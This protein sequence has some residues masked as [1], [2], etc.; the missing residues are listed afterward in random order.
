MKFLK[1]KTFWFWYLVLWV[2]TIPMTIALFGA[3]TGLFIGLL[4][5]CFAISLS[6]FVTVFSV[7]ISLIATAAGLIIGGIGTMFFSIWIM[8]CRDAVQGIINFGL[9]M[10]ALGLGILLSWVMFGVVRYFVAKQDISD[11][12]KK[13]IKLTSIIALTLFV[14]G[15]VIFTIAFA[16]SGWDINKLGYN[17]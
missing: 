6:F 5:A 1:S 10:S 11:K 13:L 3:A 4:A 15:G 16:H 17:F 7:L 2:V 8:F 14:V 12:T 9:G